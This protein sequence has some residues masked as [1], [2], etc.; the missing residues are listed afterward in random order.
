[1]QYEF[2]QSLSEY[3]CP[4]GTLR[5]NEREKKGTPEKGHAH[6]VSCHCFSEPKALQL[7]VLVCL[8]RCTE[9][10]ESGRPERKK[11]LLAHD[12]RRTRKEKKKKII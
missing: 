9:R 12:D 8:R 6:R 7:M 4:Q 11:K 10:V 1:M 5:R 2:G 3:I